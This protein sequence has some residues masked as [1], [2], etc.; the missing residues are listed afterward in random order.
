MRK[1]LA[2]IRPAATAS[3]NFRCEN[4]I[5]PQ[6]HSEPTSATLVTQTKTSSGTT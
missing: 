3:R 2:L 1:L 6:V 4:M 5:M